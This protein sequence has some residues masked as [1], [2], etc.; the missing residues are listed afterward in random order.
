MTTTRRDALIRLATLAGA[1]LVSA[2][3]REAK[4]QAPAAPTGA[5]PAGAAPPP[6]T[7]QPA[8]A[9]PQPPQ[10]TAAAPAQASPTPAPA[11]PPR[12]LN[13]LIIGDS[14]A[15]GL[16]LTLMGMARRYA[17]L[18]ITNETMHA[19][20]FAL[21]HQFNWETKVD[22]VL[23]R[24][25]FDAAVMWIGL[26]DFRP[27]VDLETRARYDFNTAAFN[28]L[29]ASRIDALIQRIERDQIPLF[30]LG[31]P[32]IR[33]EQNDRAM[34]RANEMQRDRVVAAGE[35]WIDTVPITSPE[36]TFTPFLNDPVRGQQ[37]IRAEDGSHF[38][39]L[40]YQLVAATLLDAVVARIPDLAPAVAP[41]PPPQP[42]PARR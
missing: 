3:A 42:R 31:L 13:L 6:V 9:A 8:P 11:A 14:L 16:A 12:P 35:T 41:A 23:R 29:Y 32:L 38:T 17:A 36:R 27:L 40:G 21:Y 24:Q 10:P 7:G 26:N 30:W 37:R 22:E 5:A 25:R 2:P 33:H 20:G 39:E 18:R 1:T 19:T 28:Q 15:Q 4:A 34:R